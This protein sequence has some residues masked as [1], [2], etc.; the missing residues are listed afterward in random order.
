MDPQAVPYV[1]ALIAAALTSLSISLYTWSRHPKPGAAA[2]SVLMLSG[3]AYAFPY[4]MQIACHD[5]ETAL[6][7]YKASFPGAVMLAPAWLV[8]VLRY[9]DRD[10][11]L[12]WY[13]WIGLAVIPVLSLLLAWTNEAHHLYGT[14]F[15]MDATGPFPLLRWDRGLGFWIHGAY[16][17]ALTLTGS[18]LLIRY[19][20]RAPT[21]Y[22]G[23]VVSLFIGVLAPMVG[24][25]IHMIMH[26]LHVPVL[27]QIDLAPITLPIT[28]IAW[29]WALFRFRLL[30]VAPVARQAIIEDME[31]SIAVVD[32][33]HRVVYANPAL[34]NL[35]GQPASSVIGRAASDALPSW[36]H[37]IAASDAAA[38]NQQEI[39]VDHDGG[40]RHFDLRRST[41]ENARGRTTGWATIVRDITERKQ[42]QQKLEQYAADLK[43][44]NEELEQFGYV[45]SHDLR[46]PLRMVASYLELLETRYRDDLDERANVYIDFAVDGAERMQAMIRALLD[47][48]RVETRGQAFVPVDTETVLAHTL[49]SLGPRIA[50]TDAEVTHDPLPTVMADEAQLAQ[51]FQNLIANALKFRREGVP[52]RVHVTAREGE[53]GGEG[54]GEWIISVTDNGIGIDPEQAD[55]LF[56]IFQRLHTADE[57]PGL[58]L[59]LALC[60]RIVERHGGRIWVESEPGRGA[61]FTFTLP[62]AKEGHYG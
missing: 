6:V 32:T 12:T 41:L 10:R 50:E 30:D 54:E 7:W 29:A 45:V 47:L 21:L 17:Y 1:T 25:L 35:I 53:R 55:R 14:H 49:T 3:A 11:W 46:E 59:G 62:P 56:R 60:K 18:Y 38:P 19:A 24:N 2:L 42:A 39:V 37:P 9:T 4:A 33:G 36:L 16:A 58:G 22:R 26:L 27:S 15:H 8:F 52:P 28:G 23:Q 20:L 43:S 31:D 44:S 48:S 13:H 61:T 40:R 51:V 34:L 5:L 57:Y